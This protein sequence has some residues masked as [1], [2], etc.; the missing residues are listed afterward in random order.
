MADVALFQ[1]DGA[2]IESVFGQNANF[3][4]VLSEQVLP[5]ALKA[6]YRFEDPETFE[7]RSKMDHCKL[8]D[9]NQVYWREILFRVHITVSASLIRTCRLTDA[10]ARE[11]G[12]SNLPGWASCARALIESV[13]DSIDALQCIPLTVSE[14]YHSISR[15]I[16]GEEDRGLFSAKELEEK[17]IEFTHARRLGKSERKILPESH[18]AKSTH[19]YKK[20]LEEFQVG[21]VFGLYKTLC[22]LS[23]PAAASVQYT[24]SS[25]DGGQTFR[26]S[27]QNDRTVIDAIL[28]EHRS[29]FSELMMV[30]F[31]PVFVSFLLLEEFRMFPGIPPL[32]EVCFDTVP[33]WKKVKENLARD[34]E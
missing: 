10:T 3:Y 33:L 2:D 31:N 7:R 6:Q 29:L 20:A 13:G 15:C 25:D 9:I 24:F 12:A 1:S 18:D 32:R 4:V 14:N 11:Y 23:H 21:D 28:T 22:E 17:L 27:D 19:D 34:A 8:E 26:I 30:V 16:A 5:H